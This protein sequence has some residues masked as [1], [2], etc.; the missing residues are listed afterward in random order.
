MILDTCV[1]IAK[2]PKETAKKREKICDLQRSIQSSL[3]SFF[4][5]NQATRTYVVSSWFYLDVANESVVFLRVGEQKMMSLMTE[6][7]EI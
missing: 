5:S 4:S 2:T 1:K 6:S 7:L 3:L